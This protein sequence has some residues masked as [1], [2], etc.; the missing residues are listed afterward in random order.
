LIQVYT[1]PGKGK[2]TAAFGLAMRAAGH[3]LGVRVIQFMK[4]R[5]ASGE[6]IAASRLG[7]EVFRYGTEK[8]DFTAGWQ[9]AGETLR[10]GR[11][12]LLIMDEFIYGFKYGYLEE[13]EILSWLDALPEELEVVFTG[14]D[15]PGALRERAHLVSVITPEKHYYQ[16]GIASRLGIEY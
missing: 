6:V 11:H 8:E 7:I 10:E 3:D 14:R 15:A 4:G 13:A 9:L 5:Y 12:Q 2:T 1:G 16:E